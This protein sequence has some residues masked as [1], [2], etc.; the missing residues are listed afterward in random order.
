[1][2]KNKVFKEQKKVKGEE[3]RYAVPDLLMQYTGIQMVSETGIIERNG[4]YDKAYYCEENLV[5]ANNTEKIKGCTMLLREADVDFAFYEDLMQSKVILLVRIK[6]INF[7]E[8]RNAFG[9]LENDMQS[10]MHTFG[11][12]LHPMDANERM[13]SMHELCRSDDPISRMDVNNYLSSK[14]LAW[15]DDVAMKNQVEQKNAICVKGTDELR[16][17]FYIRRM[18]SEY[19]ADIY[20][21]VKNSPACKLV[22]TCYEP[23]DDQYIAAWVKQ[24]YFSAE[25]IITSL[26]R[27]N[28]GIGRI[29]EEGHENERRYVFASLYFVLKAENGEAL[30]L[31]RDE[32]EQ[33]LR[34]YQVEITD[35]P[36]E[37]KNA[38][39][40]LHVFLPWEPA[41]TNLM[42]TANAVKMNPFYKDYPD[43]NQDEKKENEMLQYFDENVVKEEQRYGVD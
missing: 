43:K 31:A 26:I 34:E 5:A 28:C 42:L 32:L 30:S 16:G 38:Y 2:G 21:H 22:V 6:A 11:I 4:V 19:A 40:A 35:F 33:Q 29:F 24:E 23:I 9:V 18:A 39:Q 41:K 15:I 36:Y 17:I 37:Q 20:R 14:W 13:K 7:E 12:T 3:I 8:A 25:A 27:K 10:N 1:M